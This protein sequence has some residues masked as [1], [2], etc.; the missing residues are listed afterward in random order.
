MS[1]AILSRSCPRGQCSRIGFWLKKGG[2]QATLT[3]QWLIVVAPTW[4]KVGREMLSLTSVLGVT[5][6][7]WMLLLLMPPAVALANGRACASFSKMVAAGAPASAVVLPSTD[8]ARGK[9]SRSA[10]GSLKFCFDGNVHWPGRQ[11]NR[12]AQASFR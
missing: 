12:Q 4:L 6:E 10:K 7:T 8:E 11:P 2:T 9:R 1:M 5:R 3:V